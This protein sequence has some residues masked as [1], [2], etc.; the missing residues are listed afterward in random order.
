MA[1]DLETPRYEVLKTEGMLELRSYAPYLVAATIVE[2]SF[3]DASREGFRTIADFIFGNNAPKQKIAM[4][5]PVSAAR[6]APEGEKIAMTAPVSTAS[7]KD[8]WRV[9]F[10]MP[11]E[12]TRESL[13]TPS[14]EKVTIEE[15]PARCV[16]SVRFS[17]FT[18]SASM[19]KQTKKLRD[20]LLKNNIQ[21]EVSEASVQRYND[22]FTLPWNRRNEIHI[23]ISSDHCDA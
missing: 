20:W 14:N 13:P 10:M 11:S 17:G 1:D 2:G 23:Q 3:D 18:T 7:T 19:T 22:P 21:N 4:T 5:A 9:T 16:A 6:V 12:Y 15:E 8:G